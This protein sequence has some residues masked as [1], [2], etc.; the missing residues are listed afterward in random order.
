MIALAALMSVL[1]QPAPAAPIIADHGCVLQFDEIPHSAIMAVRANAKLFYGHT[2]H[3]SQLIT[4]M[5][6]LAEQDTSFLIPPLVEYGGDLGAGD[7]L[8]WVQTTRDFLDSQPELNIVIWSWCG[9]V[10]GISEAGI[11]AYLDSMTTLESEY[12]GVI[13]VYMTGHL[14]GTGPD[15]NLYLRNNQIRSYCTAHDK[16]LFDFADIESY[17]PND[18]WYP[19]GS[20]DCAWCAQWCASHDCPVCSEC[21]HSHCF[22]CYQKG[23]AAWWL[24]ARLTGWGSSS[25][26]CGDADGSGFISVSDVVFLINYIFDGGAAPTPLLKADADCNGSI[27]ISDAVRI[28]NY[29][30]ASA[31]APCSGCLTIGL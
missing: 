26:V 3:G 29:I 19:D 2:S 13:F 9:G 17:N 16:V 7:N 6:I 21:A 4:G 1:P 23:K 27:T 28:I 25:D 22:N 5:N 10:S 8:A 12:P 30:F 14:D 24:L 31:A 18:V 20:D 11:E 15:G